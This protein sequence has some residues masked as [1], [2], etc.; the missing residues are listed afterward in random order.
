[1]SMIEN[2]EDIEQKGIKKFIKQEEKRWIKDNKI[3]CVHRK[4]YYT[5]PINKKN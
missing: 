5:I 1:M 4:K 3:F 2:L